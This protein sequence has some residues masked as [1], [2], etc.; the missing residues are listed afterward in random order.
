VFTIQDKTNLFQWS[1]GYFEVEALVDV[2]ATGVAIVGGNNVAPVNGGASLIRRFKLQSQT[3]AVL[4]DVIDSHLSCHVKK[5]LTLSKDYAETLAENEFYY[6][7]S[8]ATTTI[9]ANTGLARRV[10]VV[11]A[12][13]P[14]GTIRFII[15]LANFSIFQSMAQVLLTGMQLKLTVDFNDDVLLLRGETTPQLLR[16]TVKKFDLWLPMLTLRPKYHAQFYKSLTTPT[17]WAYLN[18]RVEIGSLTQNRK[19]NMKITNVVN[20]IKVLMFFITQTK[21]TTQTTNWQTFDSLFLAAGG[22]G[23]NQVMTRAR[24]ELNGNQYYPVNDYT[25]EDLPRIY[26]DVL[27]Y[28]HN[29]EVNKLDGSQ[30]TRTLFQQTYSLLYFDLSYKKHSISND[31]HDINIVVDLPADSAAA[32]RPYVVL[33]S[34]HVATYSMI[35]DSQFTFVT[36]VAKPTI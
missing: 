14:I 29:A 31:L 34:E 12:S 30:L 5:L 19:V 28:G 18:E 2:L 33:L 35:N 8:S 4:Y 1:K 25:N 9:A 15:P 3:G 13:V 22:I 16:Y 11:N 20:P 21:L 27:K 26:N 23:G 6:L 7:D 24:L 36:D 10:A 32:F 17:K